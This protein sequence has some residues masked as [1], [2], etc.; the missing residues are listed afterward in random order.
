MLHARVS[1]S[2]KD[3]GQVE[4]LEWQLMIELSAQLLHSSFIVQY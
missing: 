1:G 4:V 3:A 2:F